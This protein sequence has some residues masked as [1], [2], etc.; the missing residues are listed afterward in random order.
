MRYYLKALYRFILLTVF[1]PLATYETYDNPEDVMG[2]T[3]WYQLP[4]I[5]CV[6]FTHQDGRTQYRW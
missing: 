3:G 4:G 1:R 2:Y 6:A 5:G